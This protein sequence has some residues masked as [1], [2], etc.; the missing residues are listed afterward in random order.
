MNNQLVSI[1]KIF[2]EKLFR[3]PDYQRGYAWSDK[4]LKDYWNDLIQLEE[5][6]NHYVGVLTFENVPSTEWKNWKDD[7]WIIESRNY[8]PLYVVD[9]QQRLTTTIILIQAITENFSDDGKLN[10]TSIEKIK[11]KFIFETKDNGISR[12]YIFGYEKDNPS[13]E[14]LKRRIFKENS[15]GYRDEETIYTQ[16]LERAKEYFIEKIKN[17]DTKNIESIYK[18]ITQNLLFNIY[19]ISE[20][21]DVFVPFET[22]NNRG[23]K[24]STLE[25]LKNR[26]IYLSTKFKTEDSEKDQLRKRINDSWKA[27]YHYLG[28]NKNKPLRDD[29]FLI[30]HF[31]ITFGNEIKQRPDDKYSKKLRYGSYQDIYSEFLLEEVY[32]RKNIL[33]PINGKKLTIKDVNTYIYDLQES[34]KI[35]YNIYNPTEYKYFDDEEKYYLDKLYRINDERFGPLSLAIYLTVKN[36]KSRIRL[37]KLLERHRFITSFGYSY[38]DKTD[39]EDLAISFL[40]DKSFTIDVLIKTLEDTIEALLKNKEYMSSVIYRF[41]SNG[42]Y[43]WAIIKYLLFEY[44]LS[45]KEKT[46][47]KRDKIDWK[48]YSLEKDEFIT[49]EHIYPQKPKDIEWTSIFKYHHKQNEKLCNS[50]GN[51]LPLSKPKNSS[52]QNVPFHIKVDNG[53]NQIGYR[54]GS[55]SEIEVSKN[56][57]WTPTEILERGMRILNFIEERWNIPLGDDKN[58]IEILG[59]SFMFDKKY[60]K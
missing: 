40:S 21:I 19:T 49:V 35:W 37:I 29:E 41:K 33:E 1:S 7:R 26:L 44:E 4:Q 53:K 60:S 50:L 36:K 28:K 47:T 54:Y 43:R 22:M 24:L 27:V 45:L 20:D 51:L 3:I 11:E 42:F 5:N 34:V 31:I 13:Y 56:K 9:G 6:K 32:T 17:L 39:Y 58:K 18:K 16:N 30:N 25:L 46:K 15:E 59:L 8:E 12:S 55:Y 52:L 48:Q 10:Y 38:L 14:F 57:Q 2:T 23:M